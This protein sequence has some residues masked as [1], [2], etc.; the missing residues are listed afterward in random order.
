MCFNARGDWGPAVEP[1]H[2]DIDLRKQHRCGVG[3]SLVCVCTLLEL[4]K[5]YLSPQSPT[6]GL[7]PCAIGGASLDEWQKN[8]EGEVGDCELP[9]RH[10]EVQGNQPWGYKPGSKNLFGAMS[11][12]V[13]EALKAA[14]EGS[15]LGGMLWYQGETDAAKED[16]AET[17]GD[18]FQ[19][20]IEDV[21]GLGYPDLNIFT[22]AVTGTTARLPYL[23]RVRDAQLFAG[24][25][26]GIAGVWVTDAFGL[27]MFPDGLH[28][29]TKAQVELGERMA[30]QIFTTTAASAPGRENA[31]AATDDPTRDW[32]IEDE[33][34]RKAANDLSCIVASTKSKSASKD[35]PI[36]QVH[37]RSFAKLLFFLEPRPTPD[38]RLL[39]LGYG[40]GVCVLAA[41]LLYDLRRIQGICA[42]E[43]GIDEA[44]TLL[45]VYSGGTPAV[46]SGPDEQEG[47]KSSLTPPSNIDLLEGE[48]AEARWDDATL[49]YAASCNFDEN[50]MLDV[51]RRC[52]GSKDCRRVITL[53][54]PLP[55]VQL[56]QGE[57]GA[58]VNGEFKVVWQCQV[59]GYRGDTTVAFVHH[60]V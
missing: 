34:V 9:A 47:P 13:D 24:S 39:V 48:V 54:K 15:H 19:T 30:L 37:F 56:R 40:T 49:V 35:G 36:S 5:A 20:L 21:R 12:R 2:R 28:L 8:Y 52:R 43:G 38:D 60:R 6:I 1:L 57:E 26:M 27:P 42:A 29:V 46:A 55:P 31:R 18:R 58:V 22:V 4:R 53:G 41:A 59:E 3:P 32:A 50:V 14:P 7:V 25:P 11:A 17:Y 33:R 51:A 45:S 23:Q 44:H 10:G 16:R